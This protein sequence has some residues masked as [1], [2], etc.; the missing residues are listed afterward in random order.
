MATASDSTVS[1]F[2]LRE[3]THLYTHLIP[4]D[5]S[6]FPPDHEFIFE[7]KICY[8]VKFYNTIANQ[9]LTCHADL[10]VR[11]LRVTTEA[12]EELG[13][14]RAHIDSIRAVA[15]APDDSFYISTCQDGTLRLWDAS[16]DT[17]LHM[18]SGHT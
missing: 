9:A 5:R 1:V 13:A 17:P 7:P 8:D 14:Y 16:T 10:A 6:A 15:L 11:K 3:N 4:F 18:Y 2:S 12:V